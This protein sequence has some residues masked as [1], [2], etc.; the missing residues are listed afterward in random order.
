MLHIARAIE[1]ADRSYFFENYSKQARSVMDMLR[2]QGYVVMP[3]KPTDAMI[4]AAT[5]ALP[6]GRVKPEV[7][8]ERVFKS[9]ADAAKK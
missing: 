5:N 6:E 8:V 3:S 9:M 4:E 7:L 2:K 1:S